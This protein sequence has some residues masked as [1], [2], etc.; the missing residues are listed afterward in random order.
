MLTKMIVNNNKRQEQ[1]IPGFIEKVEEKLGRIGK[2]NGQNGWKGGEV[3]GGKG[4]RKMGR[5]R[6]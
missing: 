5:D 1:H 2:R 6:K 3:V 4:E